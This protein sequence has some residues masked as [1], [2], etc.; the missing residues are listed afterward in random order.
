MDT[1]V[2]E[3]TIAALGQEIKDKEKHIRLLKDGIS[4]AKKVRAIYQKTVDKWKEQTQQ[5]AHTEQ[6]KG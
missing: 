1:S 2:L 5:D 6:K 4:D 3:Q